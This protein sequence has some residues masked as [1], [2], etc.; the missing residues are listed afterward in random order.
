MH[1]PVGDCLGCTWLCAGWLGLGFSQRQRVR[2]GGLQAGLGRGELDRRVFSYNPKAPADARS[3]P[4]LAAGDIIRVQD[5]GLSA[6][7]TVM[8]ELT[9]PFIGV[10]S[11]YRI[12]N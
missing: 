9:A 8:N 3:N 2:V 10:Y 6:S 1:R 4:V 7:I 11:L 5:S 12:F